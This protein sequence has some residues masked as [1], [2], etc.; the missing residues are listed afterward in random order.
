MLRTIALLALAAGAMPQPTGSLKG[1]VTDVQTKEPIAATTVS[2]AGTDLSATTD[3]QGAFTIAVVTVGSY[4]LVFR[5]DGRPDLVKTDVIVRSARAT[6]VD[7]EMGAPLRRHEDVTVADY[8]QEADHTR[9]PTLALGSEELRRAAPGGD[10]SRAFFVLPG[11]V[12]SEDMANDLV[13][14]GGSPT[15]NGFYIDNIPVP[16]INHFPQ[17]GATGGNVSM[18]NVDFIKDVE[19]LTGGFGAEYGDH[20][21]SVVDIRYREGNR[22]AFNAQVDLNLLGFGG[23]AE[24]PLAGG[25]GSWMISARRSYLDA[26]AGPLG[27]ASSSMDARFG[28]VQGKVVYDLSPRH[29]L[30]LLNVYGQSSTARDATTAIANGGVEWHDHFRQNTSGVN[31]RG[32]WGDRAYSNTSVSYAF[33]DAKSASSTPSANDAPYRKDY[34]DGTLSLRNVNRIQLSDTRHIEFGVEGKYFHGRAFNVP[35]QQDVVISFWDG[36]VFGTYS[37]S[38]LP[39]LTATLGLRAER[40]PYNHRAHIA[41][42]ISASFAASQRLRFTASYG[43]F[44]QNLPFALVKQSPANEQLE[45]LQAT[46]YVAGLA[47]RLA[48][49]TRLTLEAYD[50]EYRHFPLAPSLPTRFVI[51]DVSGNDKNF[52]DYDALVDTG[53]AYSRGVELMLQKK[54]TKSFY[55]IV[56][57]SLFRSRYR[58]LDGGWHYRLYDNRYV[59]NVTAGY[60][61]G[62]HWEASARWILAGG[63]GATPF[64]V[65][66]WPGG[67]TANLDYSRWMGTHLPPYHTLGLRLDRRVFYRRTTM[68]AYIDVWNVYNRQN[69]RYFYWNPATLTLDAEHQWGRILVFGI[70]YEL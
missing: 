41:P 55:S 61:L 33:I 39:G 8:F 32:L 5:H 59:A 50:K 26:L 6:F 23:G 37:L 21:S 36:S 56:S 47:W 62:K 11:V 69:V 24:G 31:W 13:V 57:G 12:Q 45:P 66:T 16:N 29:S 15:E 1:H 7:A 20:L 67:A 43:V 48:P 27:L 63:K 53:R 49:A 42:R 51:D 18:L 34:Y 40:N 22:S 3:K 68:T 44:Y 28:D 54:L 9:P 58:D 17:E 60:R 19:L 64:Q 30:T 65:W 35:T 4:S 70:K 14:R 25:K 52:W 10:V 38:P 46:H 2:V